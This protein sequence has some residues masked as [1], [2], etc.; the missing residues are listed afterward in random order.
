MF[1][2]SEAAIGVG[3]PSESQRG[4]CVAIWLGLRNLGPLIGG[5]ISLSLNL[6]GSAAGKVSYTTYLALIGIQ[7]LG[8]PLTFLLS[9]PSKVRRPDGTPIPHV[10]RGESSFRQE[11]KAIAKTIWQPHLL[12]LIPIFIVGIFGTTFQSVY[13]T[14]YFSVRSRALASLLTAVANI[15]A[16]LCVGLVTDTKKLGNQARRAKIVWSFFAVVVTALWTWQTVTQ[17]HFTRHPK[18]AVDWAGSTGKF[19][20]AIAVYILWKFIYEAQTVFLYWL[21]GTFPV[22]DGSMPRIMGVLRTFESVGSCLS[23]AVG[24]THWPPLNQCVLS[25]A[26]WVA[27]LVPTTLAIMRVPS[28]RIEST[29]HSSREDGSVESSDT[30]LGSSEKKAESALEA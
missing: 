1:W 25:F 8:L 5:A 30:Q 22:K 20:N 4:R 16:D 28:H 18:P 19:N 26:F 3:Y 21:V 29:S 7:C 27:C 6:K 24:A 14:D 11:L 23:Y 10:K 2:A 15:C 9:P 17:V 13:L 12:L